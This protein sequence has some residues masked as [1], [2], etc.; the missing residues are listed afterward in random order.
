MKELI[1]SY[2]KY[3]IILFFLFIFFFIS[4][5]FFQIIPLIKISS[6]GFQ[7]NNLI[8]IFYIPTFYHSFF[9]SLIISIFL[10]GVAI[11]NYQKKLRILAFL[12]PIITVF[13]LALFVFINYN[14]KPEQL[15]Y[16]RIDDARIYFTEKVFFKYNEYT[17][18][19]DQIEKDRIS[20]AI[21]INKSNI[22][23]HNNCPLVFS[24]DKIIIRFLFQNGK[25]EIREFERDK[26]RENNL[27]TGANINNDF[28]QLF[29]TFT[30]KLL[31]SKNFYYNAFLIFCIVFFI[32]TFTSFIK[33]NNYP[34]LS[35]IFNI[36]IL[37][38][39][40]YLFVTFFDKFNKILLEKFPNSSYKDIYL[41]I[42]ILIIGFI[43]RIIN[44]LF[45]KS[46]EWEI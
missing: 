2:I 23:F 40:Y 10:Y 35:I 26:L 29:N 44:R 12:L 28:T 8:N 17:F 9:N 14:P 18:Y 39:F 25:I 31:Y 15:S 45:K 37:L 19:F 24:E 27:Y 42:I 5:L 34:L 7:L 16:N 38:L 43:L 20:K 22:S 33:I 4:I 1:K 6:P 46:H 36:L 13:S 32:I 30:Y 11:F 3:L 41:S 21:M